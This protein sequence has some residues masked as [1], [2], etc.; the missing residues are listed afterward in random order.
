[1]TKTPVNTEPDDSEEDEMVQLRIYFAGPSTEDFIAE[2]FATEADARSNAAG[3]FQSG[4]YIARDS[5]GVIYYYPLHRIKRIEIGSPLVDLVN[6][7]EV[8]P[9]EIQ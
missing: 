3:I 4:R 8:R 1:M 7:R 9:G 2:E 5:D 6:E